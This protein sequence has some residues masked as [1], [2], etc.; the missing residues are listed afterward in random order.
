MSFRSSN[1][2]TAI[3]TAV[4]WFGLAIF[5]FLAV[6]HLSKDDLS[7]WVKIVAG[8]TGGLAFIG[9]GIEAL[10]QELTVRRWAISQFVFTAVTV[11]FILAA[12]LNAN[13][14]GLG[15][16]LMLALAAPYLVGAV[17]CASEARDLF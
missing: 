2:A 16:G 1:A 10:S 3:T 6:W 5:A 14:L 9:Y 17:C 11:V 4:G 13:V 15:R 7:W 12:I 8:L